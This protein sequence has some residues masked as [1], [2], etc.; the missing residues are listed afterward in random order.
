MRFSILIPVYN[1]EKYVKECIESV[2]GQDYHDYE[3]VI[4]YDGSNDRSGEICDDYKKMYPD[5][6]RVIHKQNAG[7]MAARQ[8]GFKAALGEYCIC[9]DSDDF[10]SDQS[11]QSLSKLIDG[12]KPDF[13]LYDLFSYDDINE[14][15][16][17]IESG[18][19]ENEKKYNNLQILKESLLKQQ[20]CNWSMCGKCIKRELVSNNDLKRYF[21]VAYGE[22]TLQSV[23]LY[24]KARCFV[25]T[26]KQV[27]NYRM[28][29]G[30]TKKFPLKYL[31]D[32]F[33]VTDYIRENCEKW[34]ADIERD[35][36]DYYAVILFLFYKNVYE[37][38]QSYSEVLSRLNNIDFLDKKELQ[39][40]FKRMKYGKR[41]K[42][43]L[44]FTKI[45]IYSIPYLYCRLKYTI[46]QQ[47]H[48][49]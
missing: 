20:Y 44:L 36:R 29:S 45:G 9:L 7:L 26:R 39:S 49:C 40:Y 33:A 46:F 43:C 32:F 42:I 24:N 8:D 4:I 31:K 28:G 5:K 15:S 14:R 35:T 19:F 3:I 13:I 22:D 21:D 41:D 16:C 10:L 17:R 1:V 2:L 23:V 34:S 27:Y 47:R 11:L 25:Y 30:M 37:T 12:F 48:S 6:I 18:V 38:S